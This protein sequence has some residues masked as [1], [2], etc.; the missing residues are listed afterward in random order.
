MEVEGG[1]TKHFEFYMPIQYSGNCLVSS[2]MPELT[3][4]ERGQKN[5]HEVGSHVNIVC[6]KAVN[7]TEKEQLIKQ[8]ENSKYQG[9]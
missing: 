3:S 2:Q 6:I 5:R 7:E 1:N 4:Q 8:K 9:S